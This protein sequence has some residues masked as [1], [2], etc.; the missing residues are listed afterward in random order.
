MKKLLLLLLVLVSG[1]LAGRAALTALHIHTATHGVITLVLA[2]EPVLTFNDDRSITIEVT[3]DPEATPITLSVDDVENCEYGDKYDY[4]E[5]V[6]DI[7]AQTAV[8]VTFGDSGVTF[9]G[10]DG[11]LPVEVYDL[12]GTKVAGTYSTDGTYTLGY[13]SLSHGVYVVRI[14]TFA[15]K[16]SF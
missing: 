7:T 11:N 5:G 4:L 15:T 13:D 1:A 6:E 10:F 16:I 14:G 12:R 9:S 3:K 2:K 8:A